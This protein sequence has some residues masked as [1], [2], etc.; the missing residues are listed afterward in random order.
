MKQPVQMSHILE[1]RAFHVFAGQPGKRTVIE[2][3]IDQLIQ[4]GSVKE[5]A[6][7]N[8]LGAAMERETIGSTGIGHGIAI[9]HCRT[10]A[11]KSL[12]CAFGS[13]PA[14]IDFESLDNRPV[15]AVFMVLSP[16]KQREQHLQ[17]MKSF[18]SLIRRETFCQMLREVHSSKDLM[19]LLSQFEAQPEN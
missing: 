17:L 1:P 4:A 7:L 19:H 12:V 16:T 11:V 5:D 2:G 10:D 6:R 15:Y 18:A 13:T 14:G 9:P 8:L 3:L